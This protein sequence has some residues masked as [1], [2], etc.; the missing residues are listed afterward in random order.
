MDSP[1]CAACGQPVV[2]ASGSPAASPAPPL[3]SLFFQGRRWVFCGAACRLAFKRNA[4]ALVESH[5]DRG[6][7]PYPD[8]APAPPR[9]DRRSPFSKLLT[10]AALKARDRDPGPT[11]PSEPAGATEVS[12]PAQRGET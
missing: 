3:L 9:A 4:A 6:L 8:A 11:A 2:E 12:G 1:V 5:P 10:V 7:A